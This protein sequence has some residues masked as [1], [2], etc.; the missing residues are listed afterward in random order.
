MGGRAM[1]MIPG[2]VPNA[3]YQPEPEP[4]EGAQALTDL[5]QLIEAHGYDEI[6]QGL[7]VLSAILAHSADIG[8]A[9][10][11]TRLDALTGQF[12]QIADLALLDLDAGNPE[13]SAG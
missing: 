8:Y 6:L 3:N 7:A 5:A 2:G 1:S 10:C 9:R 4:A 11:K 13:V 12:K